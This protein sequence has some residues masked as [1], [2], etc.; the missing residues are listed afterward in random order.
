MSDFKTRME[1]SLADA[2]ARRPEELA[3]YE[4]SFDGSPPEPMYFTAVFSPA[5]VSGIPVAGIYKAG[6]Y[7]QVAQLKLTDHTAPSGVRYRSIEADCPEPPSGGAWLDV[8]INGVGL[9]LEWNG[10]GET[11]STFSWQTVLVSEEV[12]QLLGR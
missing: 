9:L 10:H 5:D 4:A 12:S 6:P 11:P 7:G 8:V 2:I 3:K 1:A